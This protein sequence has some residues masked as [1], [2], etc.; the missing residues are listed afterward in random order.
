[1][2]DCKQSLQVVFLQRT[3][4]SKQP[5]D[6]RT[7]FFRN[8]ISLNRHQEH[9]DEALCARPLRAADVAMGSN[10]QSP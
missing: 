5:W 7:A 8:F 6:R 1:M 2:N 4:R 10:Y 9:G 3:F